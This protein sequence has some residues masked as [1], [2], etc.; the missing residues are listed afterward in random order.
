[1]KEQEIV[2]DNCCIG[3]WE[4]DFN[5]EE[6]II[7]FER[8]VGRPCRILTNKY[9]IKSEVEYMSFLLPYIAKLFKVD[10]NR[11]RNQWIDSVGFYKCFG[12]RTCLERFLEKQNERHDR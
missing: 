9:N 4:E 2:I 3:S 6:A 5:P 10:R 1:M 8:L 11:L 7:C 12:E